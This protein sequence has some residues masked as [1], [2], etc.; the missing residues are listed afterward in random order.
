MIAGLSAL[1]GLAYL[2]HRIYR[3]FLPNLTARKQKALRW[4]FAAGVLFAAVLVLCLTLN[5]VNAVIVLLHLTLF[6]LLCDFVF[7]AVKKLRK[8]GFVR[9]L[10]WIPALLLTAVYLSY[11]WVSANRVWI[12][13]YSLST[14]K[15]VEPLRIVMFAD[16][17][18]GTTFDGE[19]FQRQV[20][21]MGEQVP[22][23]VFIC[24]DFVDEGTSKADMETACAALGRLETTYGVFYVFGNHDEGAYG[25]NRGYGGEELKAELVKNG[26]NVLEDE[27]VALGEHFYI[28]GRRDRSSN[29][30]G[31]RRAEIADLLS[32][33][34]DDKYVIVLDHQPN[35]YVKESAA[36]A[37]LVLSGHT[38][39]G[40]MIPIG[41]MSD[42]FGWNDLNYG[43]ERREATDFI[44]TS[45]ISDWSIL[46]KTGCR[47][48]FVV[49]DIGK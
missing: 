36:G 37:D 30:R 45:G 18:I 35:D 25:S 42:I 16:A 3:S 31:T 38:H 2:A 24:G 47:S 39:G 29:E 41:M 11:G 23:A 26:V 44:V 9:R 12:K 4:L 48:E 8:R 33:V 22:D 32:N 10:E 6:W 1:A 17:H 20:K 15:T 49:I 43:Y 46:F 5:F 21:R 27:G 19:G 7:W 14:E 13:N 34:P 28:A 40:Q